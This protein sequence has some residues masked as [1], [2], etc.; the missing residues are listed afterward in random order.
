MFGDLM[1]SPTLECTDLEEFRLGFTLAG[2]G[3]FY[4]PMQLI[5]VAKLLD[6]EFKD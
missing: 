3:R 5:W 2:M 6:S 1:C 4:L